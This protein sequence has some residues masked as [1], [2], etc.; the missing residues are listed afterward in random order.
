VTRKVTTITRQG[1][2]FYSSSLVTDARI[3]LS[4]ISSE[5]SP[6][7]PR[8]VLSGSLPL[9]L[10]RPLSRPHSLRLHL[11]YCSL[12]CF[13]CTRCLSHLASSLLAWT[14][15][16]LAFR[17]HLAPSSTSLPFSSGPSTPLQKSWVEHCSVVQCSA[18]QCSAVQCSAVQ[19]SA[20]YSMSDVLIL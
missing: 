8:C 19:C 7:P 20:L 13:P 16:S 5:L 2:L 9:S 10:I 15:F 1:N 11:F 4:E 18:V 17:C 3:L 14:W 6:P 12:P